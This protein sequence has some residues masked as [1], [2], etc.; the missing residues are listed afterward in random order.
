MPKDRSAVSRRNFLKAGGVGAAALAIPDLPA[1]AAKPQAGADGIQTFAADGE[2]IALKING[3]AQDIDVTPA[4]T[5]LE[6]LRENLKLTGCKEVCDRGACG[7]CTVLVNGKAVNSCMMLAVDAIG[8]EIKTVEGLA[9]DKQLDP[10]QQAFADH[11]ACQCGYCIPGFVVRSRAFL[12]E[13]KNPN[14]EQIKHGLSGNICR[15]AA[16]VRIF[17]AVEAAGRS[18]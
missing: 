3:A 9:T 7:A 6:V 5:L 15:C 12:D 17:Q 14:L 2:K 13:T 4:T 18:A 16:Y 1:N 8:A 10:V 11:D